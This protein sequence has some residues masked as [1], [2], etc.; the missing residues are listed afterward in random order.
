MSA[1]TAI[2]LIIVKLVTHWNC[3][4]GGVCNNLVSALAKSWQGEKPPP[5]VL[6]Y[7]VW[8]EGQVWACVF[9]VLTLRIEP[10]PPPGLQ[11]LHV[12]GTNSS[13]FPEVDSFTAKYTR[14]KRRPRFEIGPC[15]MP[16]T[17]PDTHWIFA[18]FIHKISSILLENSSII[19]STATI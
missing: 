13:L 15:K 8:S 9:P 1:H 7:R 17:W 18:A 4:P 10:P 14:M 16:R 2:F 19:F 3:H 6:I 5:V 12:W 11:A